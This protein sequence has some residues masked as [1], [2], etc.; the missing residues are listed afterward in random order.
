V[1]FDLDGTL[2]ETLRDL[3]D[4]L[5]WALVRQRLP[6]ATTEQV[7]GWVGDGLSMLI[8][9]AAPDAGDDVRAQI[10]ADLATHYRQ[11]CLDHTRPYPGIEEVLDALRQHGVRTAVLSNK[12]HEFTAHM[13]EAM[14]GRERFDI[15]RGNTDEALR[16]PNPASAL[17]IAAAWS[18]Q[19]SRIAFVGDTRID[20]ETARAAGMRS[21]AVTWGFRTRAEL[22]AAHPDALIDSPDELLRAL[23]G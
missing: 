23:P 21:I 12:N 17:Q 6:Q 5:N 18:L 19:P 1:I 8:R 15:V 4:A 13:V 3:A 7:G 14:F 2:A 22:A 20:V 11:H 16:K 9:R 10:A